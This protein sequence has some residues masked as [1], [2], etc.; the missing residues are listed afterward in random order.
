MPHI[1]GDVAPREDAW[2]EISGIPSV[3]WRQK[4]RPVRAR[5]L[6]CLA[7]ISLGA[8]IRSRPVRARGLK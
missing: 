2:I 7:V 8:H 5:G 4:S 3:N 6:K 1:E